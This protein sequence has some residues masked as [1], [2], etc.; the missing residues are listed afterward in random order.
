MLSNAKLVA[1]CVGDFMNFIHFSSFSFLSFTGFSP[2]ARGQNYEHAQD[3]E[4]VGKIERR[5]VPAPAIGKETEGRGPISKMHPV[6][7]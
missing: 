1:S 5:P 6:K 2:K 4:N 7:K 3:N